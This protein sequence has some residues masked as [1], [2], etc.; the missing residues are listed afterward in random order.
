[1]SSPASPSST[2]SSVAS[3]GF[4]GSNVIRYRRPCFVSDLFAPVSEKYTTPGLPGSV[5]GVLDAD[6][7]ERTERLGLLVQLQARVAIGV[8]DGHEVTREGLTLG[9]VVR[10]GI[11]VTL[12]VGHPHRERAVAVDRAREV[13][14][15]V[16]V[17]LRTET[18]R[19]LGQ[20][21]DRAIQAVDRHDVLMVQRAELRRAGSPCP[22]RR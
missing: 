20:V 21:D 9:D 2:T 16:R 10:R 13:V 6:E 15:E 22:S 5:R 19:V 7:V 14:G 17:G 11:A 18:E 4:A 1:M 8:R 3:R 12:V